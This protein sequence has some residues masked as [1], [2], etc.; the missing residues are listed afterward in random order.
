MRGHLPGLDL[1]R[2]VG[3]FTSAFPVRVDPGGADMSAP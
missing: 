2:T 1:S 3:W